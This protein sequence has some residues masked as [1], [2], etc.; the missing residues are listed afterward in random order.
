VLGWILTVAGLILSVP[1]IPGP[2]FLFF[3]SGVALLSTESRWIR[4]LLRRLR[5]RRLIRR[6]MREA[7]RVGFKIDPGPGPDPDDEMPGP[8]R[9]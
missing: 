8:G 4:R 7:E 6:A 5:E 9:S 3:L 2:G 1:L